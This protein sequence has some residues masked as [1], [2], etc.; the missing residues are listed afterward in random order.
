MRFSFQGYCSGIINKL[1]VTAG[2]TA[3]LSYCFIVTIKFLQI[4]SEL[5]RE[6]SAED[7]CI[8]IH[9]RLSGKCL[10]NL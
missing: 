4:E 6:N 10:Q 5:S 1:C 2:V 7:I 3:K 8:G 9:N